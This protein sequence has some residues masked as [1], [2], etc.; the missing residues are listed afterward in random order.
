MNKNLTLL[1]VEDDKEAL[2]DIVYLLERYFSKVYTAINGQD[3]LDIYNKNKPD[4]ILLDINIPKISGL[5]VAS[6]IRK[7]DETTPIIFLTAHSERDKL[8]KAISLQV[9][10]YIVKPFKIKELKDIMVKLIQKIDIKSDMITLE[11][12]FVLNISTYELF[13]NQQQISLTKNEI[14]LVKIL[15]L[16]RSRYLTAGEIA[17]DICTN[18][19]DTTENNIVQLISRFKKK[20][21]KLIKTNSFFIENTYGSGYRI[22]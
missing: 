1:C 17:L 6:Q 10:S 12:N 3:A 13:Y 5:E 21:L 19:N 7:N 18:D 15:F 8:L 16:N 20:V 2:E 22:K 14:L 4:I 11:N 9:I